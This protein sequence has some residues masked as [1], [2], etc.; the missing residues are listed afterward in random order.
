MLAMGYSR[1]FHNF[2]VSLVYVLALAFIQS[3]LVS[4]LYRL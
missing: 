2:R 4:G 1:S 3:V